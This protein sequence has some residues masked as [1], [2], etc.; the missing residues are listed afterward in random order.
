MARANGVTLDPEVLES[1]A[2]E[3][4]QKQSSKANPL[5]LFKKPRTAVRYSIVFF[6]W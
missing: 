2:P 4:T 1:P 5:D 6:G 3:V